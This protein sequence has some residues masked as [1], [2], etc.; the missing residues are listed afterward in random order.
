MD[1]IRSARDV[2]PAIDQLDFV[3]PRIA[4]DHQC[5]L[6]RSRIVPLIPISITLTIVRHNR[7]RICPRINANFNILQPFVTVRALNCVDFDRV[8][9]PRRDVNCAI[10]V[11]QF[12][13]P[14]RS[15]RIGL[16]KLLCNELI[17]TAP[18][19]SRRSKSQTAGSAP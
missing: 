11:F 7:N 17:I 12:N 5:V 4:R 13:P 15:Q 3:Q 16:M 18:P 19:K 10:N 6:H 1:L 14:V 8:L 9:V 2:Q